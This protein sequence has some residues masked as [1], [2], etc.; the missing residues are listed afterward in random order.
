MYTCR[1]CSKSFE[2]SRSLAAHHCPKSREFHQ[3][4]LGS[5]RAEIVEKYTQQK[6]SIYE[7]ASTYGVTHLKMT[8]FLKDSGVELDFWTNKERR[9]VRAEK[10]RI[11]SRNRY[12]VD[13]V[14]QLQSTKDKVK[15]TC[16]EKYGVTNGSA[17]IEAAIKHYILGNTVEPH[18]LM[19]FK[20][21][22]KAV[23]EATGL[24]IKSIAFTGKCY[25]TDTEISKSKHF[26]N[27]FKATVDHKIPIIVGFENSIPAHEIGAVNNLVWCARLINT[28]K[29]TMTEQ[30]F[31]ASGIIERF[32]KYESDLR[33]SSR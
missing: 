23:A 8:Q 31:R 3:Q 13:N 17:T 4:L 25:Y 12:G 21:Y 15:S 7:L 6:T 26:N 18:R 5:R 30:Q 2:K 10:A 27:L 14:S 19:E 20:Q 1:H 32:K 29:K 22:K 28:Y 16:V 11:T 9:A 33:K 24:S